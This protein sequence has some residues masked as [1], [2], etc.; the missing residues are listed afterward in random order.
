MARTTTTLRFATLITLA[1]GFLD[2]YTYLARGGVFANAQ[3]GNVILFAVDITSRQYADA[4]A[5]VWPLLAFL[6]GVTLS[7]HLKSGRVERLISHPIRWT[8]GVMAAILAVV[9]FVPADVSPTIATV[10]IAFVTAM[11]IG[12]FRNI[13]DLN[14][15]A[16][17]TTGNLMR[18][19]ES[20]YAALLDRKEAAR[21]FRIYATV[22]AVFAGGA[23]IGGVATTYLGVEAIWLPAVFL[24]VT[25]V[26][27]IVDSRRED[28]DPVPQG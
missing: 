8:M 10:P 15:I 22:V 1:C 6:V 12:L 27:F 25:L 26:F 21:E 2:S 23:V 4:M 17:A 28:D 5:H 13:G 3:T 24:A 9:G 16:V 20:G 18:M 7:A 11:L 19:V 14:Y